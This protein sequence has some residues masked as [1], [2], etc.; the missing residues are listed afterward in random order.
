[1][2]SKQVFP[3][4][5]KCQYCG[6]NGEVE[7]HE[8]H[9]KECLSNPIHRRCYSCNHYKQSDIGIQYCEIHYRD[10][11]NIIAFYYDWNRKIFNKG[12]ACPKWEK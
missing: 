10:Q 12:I 9:E 5:I 7:F 6:G 4:L 3:L 8:I 11:K 1:M 2:E